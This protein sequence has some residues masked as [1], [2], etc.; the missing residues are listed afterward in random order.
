MTHP[1]P[2]S[3]TQHRPAPGVVV[4]MVALF[5]APSGETLKARAAGAGEA[6]SRREP[7]RV[8][9]RDAAK[10]ERTVEGRV[11]VEAQDGGILLLGR[12]GRLWN[13]T[14]D[15]LEQRERVE[16]D[17]RGMTSEETAAALRAEL[18][19]GFEIVRTKRYVIASKAGTRY[20]QW[21]GALFERLYD[22]FHTHWRGKPLRLE[23]PEVPL[24]AVILAN[25]KQFVEFAAR[26]VGPQAAAGAKGY[27]SIL[28]NR[29]ILYDLTAGEGSAPAKTLEDVQRKIAQNPFN[30]ATVVHEAT[31]QIAFNTGLHTR[32]AD[33]PLWLTEGMAMYFETP[34]L[35][36]RTGWKT[37]GKVSDGR[38]NQFRDYAQK[39]RKSNSL[40]TLV[41][42]DDRFTNVDLAL[43]AYAEAWTLTHFLIKTR[44]KAYTEYLA[45]IAAKKPLEF[46]GG[47][48]RIEE[49]REVF[50][51]L[52]KLDRDFL[53]YAERLR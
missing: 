4:L 25:E 15:R 20:A 30:L 49:F 19:D 27:Y 39:R 10:Q 26:D 24:I 21:C 37:V 6:T 43:D 35:N 41:A 28:S 36:N 42:T 33:N 1:L 22:T 31:H 50:G 23:E 38:L 12:D 9:F 18:G 48:K 2:T 11:E 44:R 51:D 47:D 16:G 5:A 45:R 53:R 14:P 46:E 17:F 32:Q 13:I 8:R 7:V 34:D 52:E 29:M 40:E 3:R